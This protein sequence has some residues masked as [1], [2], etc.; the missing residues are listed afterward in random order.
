MSTL[1]A[2]RPQGMSQSDVLKLTYEAVYAYI[3]SGG[4][5]YTDFT[6]GIQ[7]EQGEWSGYGVGAERRLH[8]NGWNQANWVQIMYELILGMITND[9]GA[10]E[11]DWTGRIANAIGSNTLGT[12]TGGTTTR[13]YQILY[14]GASQGNIA[15]IL[16]ETIECMID[17]VAAYS[18]ANFTLDVEN[19]NGDMAGV[20]G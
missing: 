6:I 4:G 16:Y 5:T 8:P 2:I 9:V 20:S 12:V 10:T 19:K 15:E 13:L 1:A 3:N 7:N 17:D 14:L 18:S 11:V